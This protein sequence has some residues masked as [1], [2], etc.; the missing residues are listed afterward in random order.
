MFERVLEVSDGL[1]V[2]IAESAELIIDGNEDL[3][4]LVSEY[5]VDVSI[6]N[7]PLPLTAGMLDHLEKAEGTI[8]YLYRAVDP[9]SISSVYVGSLILNRDDFL[10]AKGAWE[11]KNAIQM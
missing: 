11:Y 4:L 8:I 3:K 9:L 5:G 6:N 1:I 2:L 10:K 7:A